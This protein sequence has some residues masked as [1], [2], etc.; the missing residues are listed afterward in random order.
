MF[1]PTHWTLLA[2][3]TL[4]GDAR[5]REALGK[6]CQG[7][8]APVL[9]YLAARGLD[10][11]Q[12]ED[13]AQ[14]FFLKLMESRVWRRADPARGKFRT[15][16]LAVLNGH[17]M[18]RWREEATLKRGGG[19]SFVSLDAC[20]EEVLDLPSAAEPDSSA[21]DRAWA[22]AL[23]DEAVA[24]VE[25]DFASRGRA[26]DFAVLR[27]FLPGVEA[28]PPQEEVAAGL[29]ITVTALRT[30]VHR[31]RQ[32]FRE[33]LRAAVRRTVAAPHEVDAEL[34]Y[35]AS[36]LGAAENSAQCPAPGGKDKEP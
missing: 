28:P 26:A 35:L 2:R 16:L 13:I 4:H 10:A 6:F 14:D 12:R 5:G 19:R 3:A 30:A 24:E 1:P 29:G 11:N 18:H 17:L 20:A 15:F 27:R 9:Q 21:F 34:R 7:Y 23:V 22:R 36:V 8:R 32:Q 31:L 25:R 33:V